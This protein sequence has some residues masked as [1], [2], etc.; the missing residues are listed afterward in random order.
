MKQRLWF[1]VLLFAILFSSADALGQRW[2]LRRYEASLGVGS[3]HSFMDI[4][5]GL[6]G[7]KAFQLQGTRP[8][9]SF[10]VRFKIQPEIAV[11]LALT[12]AMFGGVDTENRLGMA[13][14]FTTHA[15]EPTVRGEYYVISEGR[16]YGS[17]ALFNRRGMINNYNRVYIYGF[18]G[19]GALI[20]KPTIKDEDG[21]EVNEG[22]RPGLNTNL[23]ASPVFPMGIGLKYTIDAHWTLGFE[24]GGRLTITDHID[25]FSTENS[26]YNDRYILT[27]IKAVY[28]I[29]TNRRGRPVFN[30]YYR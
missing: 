18:A 16:R 23:K 21:N 2:K 3:T 15:F 8:N 7:I 14:R 6:D 27:N 22:D 4:G 24:V 19:A 10:D 26:D 1:F 30:R 11:N 12:Y 9:V 25:G 17:S 20:W 29:R 28:K 13:H 5:S